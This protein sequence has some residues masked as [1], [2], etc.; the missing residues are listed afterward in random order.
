M[1]ST[2]RNADT[3]RST[4]KGF[5]PGEMTPQE[6]AQAH[7]D[8]FKDAIPDNEYAAAYNGFLAGVEWARE[9]VSTQAKK[10][11][12]LDHEP[13][14]ADPWDFIRELLVSTDE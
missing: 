4:Q 14:S 5:R 11:L 1:G 10:F 9:N 2:E 7:I 6:A 8:G 12:S 13:H 3:T